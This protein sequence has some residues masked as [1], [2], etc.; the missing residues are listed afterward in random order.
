MLQPW[1][2]WLVVD[3]STKLFFPEQSKNSLLGHVFFLNNITH[4]RA[5]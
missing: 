4:L 1:Q 5:L 2:P 3:K